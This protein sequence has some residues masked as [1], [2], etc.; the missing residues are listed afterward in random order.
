GCTCRQVDHSPLPVDL[1]PGEERR[2]GAKVEV[3]PLSGPQSFAITL[4]TDRASQVVQVPLI[5]MPRRL[6]SPDAFANN[7]LHEGEPWEFEV[8][9]RRVR[10]AGEPEDVVELDLPPSLSRLGVPRALSSDVQFDHE[11]KLTMVDTS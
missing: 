8:V 5:A 4:E 10:L 11:T 3:R 1:R 2:L 6:L 9:H 7:Q